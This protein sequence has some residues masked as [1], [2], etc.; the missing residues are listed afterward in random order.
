MVADLLSHLDPARFEVHLLALRFLGRYAESLGSCCGLH[1]A[2]H[3][4]RW[5]MIWPR[6][7]ATELQRLAP[8][9]VHTH[10]GVWYK[11]SLAARMIS[12]P[13]LVHT[14]HG[15]H[16]PDPFATRVIDN[17][18]SRWTSA[19]V[20]VSEPLAEHLAQKVVAY[21]NRISTIPNGIDTDLF[22]P[23][24]P[25]RRLLAEL[26][27]AEGH[28]VVG[29]LGRFDSVKGYDVVVRAFSELR[30][31]WLGGADPFLV[32]AGEGPEAERLR[33]LAVALGLSDRVLFPGWRSDSHALY[34]SF[35]VFVLGSR[36]EG[37]SLSLLEAMSCGTCPVIT[38]VGGNAKVLGANLRHRLVLPDSVTALAE[39]L[40]NAL[41]EPE[42]RNRDEEVARARVLADFSLCKMVERYESLY[43]SVLSV[44]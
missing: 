13:H 6:A 26:G 25:D 42:Q 20:A 43:E 24:P 44:R 41:F 4:S 30:Q 5:T 21:P 22:V 18:A 23:G 37:T 3:L 7:L 2:P 36:S 35:D 1:V 39:G 11:T 8:D 19:V 33:E 10:S 31:T 14:D 17:L 16:F 28:P 9:I 12:L 27:V 32:L 40:R 29:S 38:N 34:R 15:R